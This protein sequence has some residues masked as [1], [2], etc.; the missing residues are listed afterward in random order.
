MP[1]SCTTETATGWL[2]VG[3][4]QLVLMVGLLAPLQRWW[5]AEPQPRGG[6]AV[7]VDVAYTLLHRLG[8]FRLAVIVQQIYY[9]YHHKQTDNPAFR[10]FWILNWA[11]WRRCRQ[12]IAEDRRQ[13]GARAAGN[14]RNAAGVG[15]AGRA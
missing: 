3:L 7:R 8:L 2:L 1:F 14:D 11:I 12:L 10:S 6:A 4:I 5:P 9:R 15:K 13:G